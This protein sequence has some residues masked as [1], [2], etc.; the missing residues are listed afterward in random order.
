[1]KVGTRHLFSYLCLTCMY[2]CTMLPN[3]SIKYCLNFGIDRIQSNLACLDTLDGLKIIIEKFDIKQ[4]L[5]RIT[6]SISDNILPHCKA[7]KIGRLSYT[8]HTFT[9]ALLHRGLELFNLGNK[10]IQLFIILYLKLN[11]NI[12][13][14]M[15]SSCYFF[16]K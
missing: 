4:V 16:S 1:M 15:V 5:R 9:I 8:F 7:M 13:N 11:L 3:Y 6:N 10:V 12:S 2:A 14:F